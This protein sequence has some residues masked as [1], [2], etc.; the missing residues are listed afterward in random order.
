MSF[1][2]RSPAW[3][4]ALAR[5]GGAFD[6]LVTSNDAPTLVQVDCVQYRVDTLM[7]QLEMMAEHV[8]QLEEELM[9]YRTVLS[10][11]RRLPLEILG[12]IFKLMFPSFLNAYDRKEMRNLGSVCRRWRDALLNASSLWKG[13][14]LGP[15]ICRPRTTKKSK[16]RHVGDYD[17]L[18]EW[19]NRAKGCPKGLIY[20][21]V[22]TGC[23]CVRVGGRCFSVDP[24]VVRF[25][26]EGPA[27]DH[28]SLQLS[29]PNC[30]RNWMAALGAS[31]GTSLNPLR[32]LRSFSLEFIDE[33][34][35][36]WNDGDDLESSVFTL[37][38][39]VQSLAVYL[40]YREDVFDDEMDSSDC[41]INIP[42]VVL[43]PLVSLT[44]RWDWE[45]RGL[46][47]LL[48]SCNA[49]ETFTLD[50]NRSEPFD[51]CSSLFPLLLKFLRA[52]RIVR[53]G[54]RLL[55]LVRTPALTSLDLELRTS[56]A[57]GLLV[58]SRL[59]RFMHMS[60]VEGSLRYLRLCHMVGVS[61]IVSLG[62]PRLPSLRH[63]VLDS[64]TV[65]SY[66]F[67][68][69]GL[70]RSRGGVEMKF[71]VLQR[72]DLL[73]LKRCQSSLSHEIQY[74]QGRQVETE[75]MITVS[76]SEDAI[77]T[78]SLL[79]SRVRQRRSDTLVSVQVIP[80][81]RYDEERGLTL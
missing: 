15:C 7:R 11:L 57:E 17:H 37:L 71:P 22:D 39:H 64:E 10:P 62:L 20:S 34:P 30:F 61:G 80:V 8:L 72:L 29:G 75:C 74:L 50:L 27:L 77:V 31:P 59:K 47:D 79:Q 40:P 81:I 25:L 53:G 48:A 21:G 13:V 5:T 70:R 78:E 35:Q 41:P 16:R 51:G 54:V 73:N 6:P 52:L 63:L 55:E 38:P 42:P 24:T 46:L 66:Y 1:S 69:V 60:E 28:L 68:P 18:L 58:P 12:E 44:I 23:R 19:F 76:Y 3:T 43:G 56:R 32:S 67:G 49:L 14:I 2:S 26:K 45:G 9:V 33:V 4:L 65:S 36:T